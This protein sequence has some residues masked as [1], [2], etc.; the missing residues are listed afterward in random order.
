MI[1]SPLA[2]HENPGSC[3]ARREYRPSLS[4]TLW[5]YSQHAP[6][7][8]LES[9]L[10]ACAPICKSCTRTAS[11][12]AQSVA[13]AESANVAEL[14]SYFDDSHGLFPH[15]PIFEKV[16]AEGSHWELDTAQLL[17]HLAQRAHWRTASAKEAG[18]HKQAVVHGHCVILIV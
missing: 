10:L 3:A 16:G 12:G 2:L 6:P 8:P 11:K 15:F 9:S 13:T 7:F 1:S 17:P 14:P 18:G 5:K 4:D